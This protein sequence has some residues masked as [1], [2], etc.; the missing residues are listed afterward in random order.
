MWDDKGHDIM[1]RHRFESQ[2]LHLLVEGWDV[3][4]PQEGSLQRTEVQLMIPNLCPGPSETLSDGFGKIQLL[5]T[6]NSK[7]CRGKWIPSVL[8][9]PKTMD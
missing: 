4:E 2:F 7:V 1:L 5:F 8:S 3:P 6:R 9:T